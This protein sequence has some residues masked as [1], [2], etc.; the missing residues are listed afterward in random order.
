MSP[1][2]HTEALN[3]LIIDHIRAAEPAAAPVS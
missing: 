1:F 2:T 3:A